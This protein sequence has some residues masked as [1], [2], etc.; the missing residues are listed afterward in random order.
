MSQHQREKHA[1]SCQLC[2]KVF[3]ANSS[4]IRHHNQAHGGGGGSMSGQSNSSQ[5]S[6]NILSDGNHMG[7]KNEVG[8]YCSILNISHLSLVYKH[9]QH[10]PL[11]CIF[12]KIRLRTF[13]NFP[14]PS[15][16]SV[17]YQS[18]PAA[19]ASAIFPPVHQGGQDPM[20]NINNPTPVGNF[21]NGNTV[22]NNTPPKVSAKMAKKTSHKPHVNVSKSPVKTPTK[23]NEDDNAFRYYSVIM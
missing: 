22:V 11:I 10:K 8:I 6:A 15:T 1:F 20:Q 2:S 23:Q 17:E 12:L 16:L 18:A 3:T 21:S 7:I 5:T 9:L 14:L 19:A 13:Q 4:L